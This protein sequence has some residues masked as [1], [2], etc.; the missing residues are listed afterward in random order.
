MKKYKRE[1]LK[2]IGYVLTDYRYQVSAGKDED[3]NEEYDF[4]YVMTNGKNFIYETGE[5]I[6]EDEIKRYNE[7]LVNLM[8]NGIIEKNK[9]FMPYIFS[10]QSVNIEKGLLIGDI[11]VMMRNKQGDV[12]HIVKA[13]EDLCYCDNGKIYLKYALTLIEE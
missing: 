1:E 11:D 12:L 3:G 7:E 4:I 6:S 5:V 2:K 13:T 10:S 9:L 8:T